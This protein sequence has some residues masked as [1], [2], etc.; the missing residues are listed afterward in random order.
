M[1]CMQLH[2]LAKP[3]RKERHTP[4]LKLSL[5]AYLEASP[6]VLNVALLLGKCLLCHESRGLTLPTRSVSY[7][8]QLQLHQQLI[9]WK[10]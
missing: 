6:I 9:G 8:V 3:C 5:H 1:C 10:Q 7:H 4:L 2:E